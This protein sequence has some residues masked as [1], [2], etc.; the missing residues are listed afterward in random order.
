MGALE[1]RVLGP[2]EVRRG[3]ESVPVTAPRLQA[4]L[5]LLLQRANEPVAQSELM[6][7]LWNGAAP[8]SARAA[9]HNAIHALRSVLGRDALERHNGGYVLNV[10]PDSLDL[11]KFRSLVAEARDAG[12][13]ERADKL[14]D[15]LACWRGPVHAEDGGFANRELSG[16][17][18]E[19][20]AALEE[21]IDADLGLGRGAELVP[22]LE[23]LVARHGSRE[24]FW[25]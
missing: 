7:Q 17:E 16:L 19:R 10:G 2:L 18:E 14:R 5:L 9:F 13:H 1:F 3:G 8:P 22:E 24:R 12:K 21:R 23:K 15:A 6:D 25:E 20:L 11:V 4:L